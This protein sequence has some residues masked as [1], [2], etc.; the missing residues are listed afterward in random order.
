MNPVRFTRFLSLSK[1]TIQ[2]R[3][4]LQTVTSA[5]RPSLRRE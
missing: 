2:R 3:D 5:E 4:E 1:G